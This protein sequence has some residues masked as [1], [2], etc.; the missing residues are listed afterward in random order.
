MLGYRGETPLDEPPPP[1]P[2]RQY[3]DGIIYI[4]VAR[5]SRG[6]II[7]KNQLCCRQLVS[8]I[9]RANIKAPVLVSFFPVRRNDRRLK[10][11]E[12][13]S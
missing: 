9:G 2:S 5:N 8:L 12:K 3:Y 6:G 11:I 7:V 4:A 13:R 10:K 1:P